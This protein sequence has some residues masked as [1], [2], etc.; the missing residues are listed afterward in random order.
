[1][2]SPEG[3][4]TSSSSSNTSGSVG[5]GG[6]CTAGTGCCLGGGG[7][8]TPCMGSMRGSGCRGS[9]G[10]IDD[11]CDGRTN[12]S[13]R[14]CAWQS[15]QTRWPCA[16]LAEMQWKW[17]VW[18]HSAVKMACPPSAPMAPRH[19]AQGLICIQFKSCTHHWNSLFKD[20]TRHS[21]EILDHRKNHV[22]FFLE[23]RREI[24][25]VFIRREKKET[26]E[27]TKQD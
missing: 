12:G 4:S 9:V 21:S 22:I 7:C 2:S 8:C 14:H 26:N 24:C 6:G 27:I 18:E 15:G 17:N 25:R 1:L 13:S 5:C 11:G 3:I 19:M 23:M 16:T 10:G 20:E